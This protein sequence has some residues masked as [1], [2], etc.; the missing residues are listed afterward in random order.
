MLKLYCY[1]GGKTRYWETWRDEDGSWVVH[2]GELG[3]LGESK[4][5]KRG[6]WRNPKIAIDKEINRLLSEGF[7]PID[8]DAHS[9]LM[10]EY[11]V[12]G[13]GSAA[14]LDKRHR[15]EERMGEILGWSG[16]GECD[17]GSI[18]SGTMEVCSFVVD[19]DLAKKVVEEGLAGSEFSDFTR[20]YME[21]PQKAT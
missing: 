8:S 16:L 13:M 19:F 21:D 3:T 17:G 14:D 10:V 1:H 18:G 12:E 11:A 6:L 20:I 2:W 5:I 9:V 15:L 4:K 7:A